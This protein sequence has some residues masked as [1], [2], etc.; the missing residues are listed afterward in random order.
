MSFFTS[1][2]KKEIQKSLD[3]TRIAQSTNCGISIW[4][5]SKNRYDLVESTGDS[6]AWHV[7]L[8][9]KNSVL[10]KNNR[11]TNFHLTEI[12]NPS[13]LNQSAFK[14]RSKSFKNLK[15]LVENISSKKYSN[16]EFSKKWPHD[17]LSLKD[18]LKG[19]FIE[20]FGFGFSTYYSETANDRP[21]DRPLTISWSKIFVNLFIND[22]Q[23]E[24]ECFRTDDQFHLINRN[25]YLCE[26]THECTYSNRN[27]SKVRRHQSVCTD[28]TIINYKADFYGGNTSVTDINS[29]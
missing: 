7:N 19:S 5:K 25:Y 20:A 23:M 3:V 29:N 1:D 8:L 24:N 14:R 13:E 21:N 22:E 6:E 4:R 10:L 9:S 12:I 2:L 17:T 18:D 16:A 26:K 15:A 28:E 27:V 11:L